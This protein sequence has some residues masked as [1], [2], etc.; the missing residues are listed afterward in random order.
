MHVSLTAQQDELQHLND[1]GVHKTFLGTNAQV[2]SSPHSVMFI[3]ILPK[4]VQTQ[5]IPYF[6]QFVTAFYYHL[7]IIFPFLLTRSQLTRICAGGLQTAISHY[8]M[9]ML[10]K[11]YTPIA[12]M[13]KPY[14]C[15]LNPSDFRKEPRGDQLYGHVCRRCL[16]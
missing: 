10:L 9:L 12:H 7:E 6:F 1:F 4:G 8:N 2:L 11:V 13:R 16:Q 5:R 3:L 14:L 15:T